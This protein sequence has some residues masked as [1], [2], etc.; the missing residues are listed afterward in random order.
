MPLHLNV[1]HSLLIKKTRR[2]NYLFIPSAAFE[3]NPRSHGF[4]ITMNWNY[5]ATAIPTIF[6]KLPRIILK[7]SGRWNSWPVAAIATA[8]A[9]AAAAVTADVRPRF[10]TQLTIVA[11]AFFLFQSVHRP[12][13]EIDLV[14][15]RCCITSSPNYLME[16]NKATLL[17]FAHEG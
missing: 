2:E 3:D 1:I 6:C 5:A 9:A 10:R 8:A 13:A 16:T 17:N 4:F 7:K 14:H 12:P 15:W 11:T